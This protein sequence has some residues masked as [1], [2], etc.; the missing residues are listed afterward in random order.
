MKNSDK[1]RNDIKLKQQFRKDYYSIE[2]RVLRVKYKIQWH[3]IYELV[4][5]FNLKQRRHKYQ[6]GIWAEIFPKG[7]NHCEFNFKILNAVCE[8]AYGI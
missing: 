1:I 2:A 7:V 3:E 5:E 4:K 8:R 6:R